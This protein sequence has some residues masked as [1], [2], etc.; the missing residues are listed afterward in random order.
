[1]GFT[2]EGFAS[3]LSRCKRLDGRQRNE[4]MGKLRKWLQ[5]PRQ[6]HDLL[7]QCAASAVLSG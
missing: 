1:M 6:L 4:L 7:C 2:F 3:V 5:P